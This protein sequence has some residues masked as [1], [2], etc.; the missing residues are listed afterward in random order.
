MGLTGMDDK[1]KYIDELMAQLDPKDIKRWM[2][3]PKKGRGKAWAAIA[4]TAAQRLGDDW[5][6]V[7]SGIRTGILRVPVGWWFSSISIDPIPGREKLT[8]QHDAL[9]TPLV[10]DT[11]TLR[12][13]SYRGAHRATAPNPDQLDLF[14]HD[15]A[16]DLVCWW[17]NGPATET[18]DQRSDREWAAVSEFLFRDYYDARPRTWPMLAGWRVIFE[19]GSPVEVIRGVLSIIDEG[20]WYEEHRP[21]WERILTL[22]ERDDRSAMLQL[23][24]TERHRGLRENFSLPDTAIADVFEQLGNPNLEGRVN[25]DYWIV[26][27]EAVETVGAIASIGAPTPQRID[28][29]HL[30]FAVSPS[31]ELITA[32][33]V[34]L[35]SD[36]VAEELDDDGLGDFTIRDAEIDIADGQPAPAYKWFDI[37]G[38]AGIADIGLTPSGALVASGSALL[39]LNEFA[40]AKAE[41]TE[42]IPD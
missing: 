10:P 22:A 21:F 30:T 23:L 28:H 39:L 24:D 25:M 36:A 18:F 40:I 1:Q 29:V 6:V 37:T 26:K 14:D 4:A 20:S 5:I 27:P 13:P 15:S 33:G 2:E 19:T 16:V 31:D 34:F 32:G 35:V 41:I 17:A 12:Q 3:P 7:G 38:R 9:T 42:W 8:L 11:I